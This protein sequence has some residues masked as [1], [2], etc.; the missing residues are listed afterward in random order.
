MCLVRYH[1]E[2]KTEKCVCIKYCKKEW[3]TYHRK[4]PSVTG[5]YG[6]ETLSYV[7]L[8]INL[9]ALKKEERVLKDMDMKEVLLKI[10]LK[11]QYIVYRY[12]ALTSFKIGSWIHTVPPVF[13]QFVET[14]WMSCFVIICSSCSITFCFIFGI[15][16]NHSVLGLSLI[17]I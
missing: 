3:E 4:F 13:L 10:K 16:E 7:L 8:F 12:T 2:W 17:H 6:R 14:L 9:K 11:T 15:G 5:D 1:Y